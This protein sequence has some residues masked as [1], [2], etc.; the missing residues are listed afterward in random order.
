LENLGKKNLV[1]VPHGV[2]HYLPFHALISG[3]GKYLIESFTVSYLPS[4][5]ILKYAR[6]KN[7]GNSANLFAAAN[8][9]TDLPPLP[10]AELEAR[11]IST[12]YP[13]RLVLKGKEATEASVKVQSP[14]YDLVLFSTHGEMIE[15]DPMRSNLRF[16]SSES[17][18]GRLTV[19]EIFDMQIKANLVTLSACETA[20]A[21]GP[22]G[23]YPKGDDLVGLSRAFIHAGAPSVLASLWIVSDNSTVALM[24]SFFQHLKTVPKAE[25]L[26]LAQLDLMKSRVSFNLPRGTGGIT[27][28]TDYH[29]GAKIDCSHP[30]FWAPFIMVGD[31]K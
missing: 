5:S 3:D 6:K 12:F 24:R 18:D 21:K 31:W 17:E 8:P 7:R 22:A 23:D 14:N 28:S 20:L 11:E 13:K 15:S 25:A 26:R 27:R 19:S 1:I 30:F 2:L 4:A 10:G 9:D 29:P 16:T